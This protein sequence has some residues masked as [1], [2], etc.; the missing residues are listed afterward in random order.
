MD[1]H[2]GFVWC[3]S[4]MN[5]CGFPHC[6][7]RSPQST[8]PPPGRIFVIMYEVLILF[9]ILAAMVWVGGGLFIQAIGARVRAAEGPEA[10]GRH[11]VS[12]EWTGNR[13][14]L[15]ASLLT[16]LTGITMVIMQ[17]AWSFS[18]LWISLALALFLVSA[19]AQGA[20]GSKVASAMGALAADRKTSTP[21][22]AG[23]MRRFE[24]L[25]W[26]DVVVLLVIVVLMVFKPGL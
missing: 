12:I 16:L 18:Q 3:V 6:D 2:E 17:D 13:I 8:G 11:I 9:H 21:E 10:Q 14:F 25:A 5:R 24:R 1:E 23:F 15:P 7:R 22:F 4:R 20:V 19:I 26:L